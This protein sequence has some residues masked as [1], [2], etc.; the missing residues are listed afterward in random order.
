MD[1]ALISLLNDYIFFGG[2]RVSLVP[3]SGSALYYA[4]DTLGSSRVIVQSTGTLCYD[5]DFV[6]FGGEKTQT[7]TCARNYKFEGK[8]RDTETQNHDFGAREYSWRFGRWVS[9]DWS[10]VPVA[11]PYANLTNPQTLNLYAMVVDD[12]ESF[13]DLDG[14]LLGLPGQP[15]GAGG[16]SSG[17]CSGFWSCLENA[18]VSDNVAGIG[19]Q[20]PSDSSGTV[21]AAVGD[22]AATAQGAVE[23]AAGGTAQ[24]GGVAACGTGVGCLVTAPAVVAGTAAEV[25]GGATAAEGFGH[26]LS[27]TFRTA[28]GKG[29][30]KGVSGGSDKPSLSEHKE[31]L[32][33]VHGKVGK[34]PKGEAGKFGSPQ[35]GTSK[36]GYRLD[37]GHPNSPH[38]AEKG[39]HINYWDYTGGKRGAGGTSGAVAIPPQD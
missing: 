34:Q 6:P 38:A 23:V 18:L 28:E 15:G 13:A 33:Q 22:F 5:A 26:L 35:R 16:E 30:Q 4:E 20:D 31:A 12:P 21:G 24:A 36:K 32:K 39:P 1:Q 27:A 17:E 9:S 7:N 2:K 19:R 29:E 37:P 25:H 8:E 10:A 14:L 3:A 11:V